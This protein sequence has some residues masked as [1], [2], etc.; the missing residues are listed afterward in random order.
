MK[1]FF[2]L[3]FWLLIL[4]FSTNMQAQQ[5]LLDKPVRAGELILFPELNNESNYYY[6]P[7]KPRLAHHADDTPQFSFLRYVKNEQTAATANTAISES[8]T[9]GGIV[10]ALVELKV[11]NEQIK[12]AQKAL[13]RIDGDG[14]IVGPV[15]FK[16]GSIALISSIAQKNGDFTKQVVGLGN[17]PILE[18]E[19]SAVSVQLNKLGSKILWE[20]FKTPTPDFSMHFEM[21]VEGYLSPKRVLIEADFDQMYKHST[22]EA[23]MASPV[24]AGEINMAMDELFDSGAIKLTQI[25]DDEQLDKLKETAYNQLINLIFDKV[26]GTGVP[27]LNQLNPTG[28]RSMLD[29]A[30]TMLQTARTETRQENERID[31]LNTER[32]AEESRARQASNTRASQVR[33]S[34][35]QPALTEPAGTQRRAE[36][37]TQSTENNAGNQGNNTA[38]NPIP[39]RQT[40]PSL[41]IAVSYQMKTVHRSG[42][43]RIDLN[44]YTQTTRTLPFDYNLGNVYAECS[45]CFREANMDDPLMKQREINASLGGVVSDD[46]KY[47]NFVNVLMRKK[48]QDGTETVDEIKIDKTA[49]NQ[50][51]NFFKMLYGWKGDNDR[52]KWL[53]YD[54]K[55]MWSVFG[56]Y[57]FESDWIPTKFG[58][59]SLEPPVVKKPVFIEVDEDF[60]T[61]NEIKA[62]E[63]KLFSKIN[64][65]EDVKT[66]NL[67][68]NKGE[69]SATM[70]IILPRN[71]EDYQYQITYFLKGKDPRTS[72]K[73]NSNYGRLDIDKF[74]N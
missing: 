30:T 61:E 52:D 29:R 65:K 37:G 23:A 19:K 74:V 53:N 60:I 24:L 56:D 67:K 27:Q 50:T 3:S 62:I 72:A 25:G 2:K 51:G 6:L 47:V 10:H 32:R 12:E 22:F 49:F 63:I 17:A 66:V 14:K 57:K 64:Q 58:S 7:D 34:N 31:R 28:Q 18:D 33:E 21:E 46:F 40:M 26:G 8:E 41:S 38:N 59:I 36:Q 44:K 35:G 70:E 68:T 11:T 9:G 13:R 39:E 71:V 4:I 16:S 69:L 20:S 15:I 55:T 73:T 48:H 5:I 54:Y 42:K 45:A 1:T 43:Y